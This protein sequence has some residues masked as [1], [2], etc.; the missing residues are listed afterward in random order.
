M[1]IDLK[2]ISDDI[3]ENP[4]V[5]EDPTSGEQDYEQLNSRLFTNH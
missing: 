4:T 3:V 5:D 2:L 1:K